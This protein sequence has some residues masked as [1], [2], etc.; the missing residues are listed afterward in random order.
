MPRVTT[1]TNVTTH[2]VVTIHGM[3][4]GDENFDDEVTD[5]QTELLGRAAPA[6]L[7]ESNHE[8]VGDYSDESW[9]GSRRSFYD[10]VK[11]ASGEILRFEEG[12]VRGSVFTLA[13]A[14]LGAG[15]LSVPFAFKSMGIALGSV[16]ILLCAVTTI[17]SLRLLT[18]ARTRT[19]LSSFE[20]ITQRLYGRCETSETFLRP[21]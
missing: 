19:G 2:T 11:G 18:M 8:E 9:E 21:V 4:N 14:T 17:F 15:A 20:E 7:F 3:G 1:S 5:E 6:P 13:S 12:S 10:F 16:L